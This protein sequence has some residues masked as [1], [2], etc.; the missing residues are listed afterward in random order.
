MKKL[1]EV[2]AHRL[3]LWWLSTDRSLFRRWGMWKNK[4]QADA[5]V[6]CCAALSIASLLS[7]ASVFMDKTTC[8]P[9]GLLI[10]P[11]LPYP[12][13]IKDQPAT[14]K[15]K[16]REDRAHPSGP[17]T[18]CGDKDGQSTDIWHYIIHNSTTHSWLDQNFPF[19]RAVLVSYHRQLSELCENN[20]SDERLTFYEMWICFVHTK[21]FCF[22][23]LL[24]LT[25]TLS[26]MTGI[27]P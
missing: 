8:P 5:T 19:Q 1:R 6:A 25:C 12:K 3:P 20:Y 17:I 7:W 10:S 15:N 11:A 23:I 24:C 26:E 14:M 21:S 16:Q 13:K 18:T 4:G 27:D 2:V 22:I 9:P